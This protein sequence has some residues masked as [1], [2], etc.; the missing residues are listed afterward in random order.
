[1]STTPALAA[2]GTVYAGTHANEL[3]AVNPDGTIR[4]RRHLGALA[5][6]RSSP[7]VSASGVVYVGSDRNRLHAVTSAGSVLWE[8]ATGGD[9]RS[10]PMVG[11]TGT[12]YFGSDDNRVYAVS[13]V[14]TELWRFATG[15]DVRSSP[16]L[17]ADAE[18]L[19]VGSDDDRLYALDATTG[20]KR[21]E[22]DLGDRDVRSSPAVG[23]DG[24]IYV[25]S[26][27]N[28]LWALRSDGTVR[29][30][31]RTGGDVQSSPAIGAD[32]TI[33]V[34]SDDSKLYAI[35]A[36]GGLRW[37]FD[38]GAEI[39]S[40]PVVDRDGNV[41]VGSDDDRL[42]AIGADGGLRWSFDTS[43]DIE[44]APVVGPTGT[45]F[46]A[47]DDGKLRA[48]GAA[49]GGPYNVVVAP[50]DG[51]D[52]VL[53]G[54][55]GADYIVGGTGADY[56]ASRGG[57]DVL[58]GGG[59]ADVYDLG[60]LTHAADGAGLS[61]FDGGT[62]YVFSTLS[63]DSIKAF[64]LTDLDPDILISF[65]PFTFEAPEPDDAATFSSRRAI[66]VTAV[67][68]VPVGNAYVWNGSLGG[69]GVVAVTRVDSWGAEIA[70][71]V[72]PRTDYFATDI[73]ERT[74][75]A[76]A[77]VGYTVVGFSGPNATALCPPGDCHNDRG[78]VLRLPH[79][80]G[81]E[82][83]FSHTSGHF[84]DRNGV[85]QGGGGP[86]K[87]LGLATIRDSVG[88]ERGDLVAVGSTEASG[89]VEVSPGVWQQLSG[90]K[91]YVV[92]LGDQTV[93]EAFVPSGATGA[94][95]RDVTALRF[96]NQR[97]IVA[98]GEVSTVAG[99]DALGAVLGTNGAPATD[100]TLV[101]ARTFG[102]TGTDSASSVDGVFANVSFP[103]VVVA[104][105]TD[106]FNAG[107]RT[108]TAAF[109]KRL[110][111]ADL[112]DVWGDADAERG[113][114]FSAEP[115]WRLLGGFARTSA[116][117]AG[118]RA[119]GFFVTGVIDHPWGL[120]LVGGLPA[121]GLEGE[122]HPV[123][124]T[125]D[126][127]GGSRTA[128][129][130]GHHAATGAHLFAGAFLDAIEGP[131]GSFV[132][133]GSTCS[134]ASCQ[135]A[136]LAKKLTSDLQVGCSCNDGLINCGESPSGFPTDPT[137]A[138]IPGE[139]GGPR[140]EPC[141]VDCA[142]GAQQATEECPDGGGACLDPDNT[143][144]GS[145]RACPNPCAG[146]ECGIGVGGA[147]CG[148]CTTG[149]CQAGE[150]VPRDGA[151]LV[152]DLGCEGCHGEELG[153]ANADTLGTA[154]CLR[155]VTNSTCVRNRITCGFL[156]MPA[157]CGEQLS[158]AEVEN[159]IQYLQG[160]APSGCTGPPAQANKCTQSGPTPP[161]C[162]QSKFISC[163]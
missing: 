44:G 26:D 69:L 156:G 127:S 105:D 81:S 148:N 159:I 2:D 138:R 50:P 6:V 88:T 20:A 147:D 151:T 109:L 93:H 107:G 57:A 117:A 31:F 78:F 36:S 144:D 34:G 48:F 58:I 39:D 111:V 30:R 68:T 28:E 24:T 131:E 103:D 27:N 49:P 125:T 35:T 102:G 133:V 3:L 8:F 140:C 89:E 106:S 149:T 33:Y 128:I 99:L 38:T 82:S 29:W 45:L 100:L 71:Y 96:N 19:Y 21:W 160:L 126:A 65:F 52:H 141:D 115:G 129:S 155:G 12:V 9:V 43:H 61:V 83:G 51:A 73:V 101:A 163:G 56:L 97:R 63:P 134:G 146:L 53:L 95:F 136:I 119:G 92:Y 132:A 94:R 72:M 113:A 10:S 85:L 1:M 145:P 130:L 75:S 40:T 42:Y 158:A 124:F 161:D 122:D 121:G 80:L 17:S 157:F 150:C 23:L 123:L 143:P 110:R 152:S 142:D 64:V 60:T 70:T 76:G 7:C 14:G 86:N 108:G 66:A 4:W 15:G 32:G 114:G 104:G 79:D 153:G 54:T 84:R 120:D 5:D 90:E 18:T 137:G 135:D 118:S 77:L 22:R 87:L 98:V 47:S 162:L 55:S 67:H 13:P 16:T 139:C 59:G 91:G 74:D 41:Y 37:L 62:N 112:V 11:P 25:G 154:P 116:A 46:V